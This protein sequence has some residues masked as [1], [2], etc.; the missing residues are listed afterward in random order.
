MELK[1]LHHINNKKCSSIFEKSVNIYYIYFTSSY[2]YESY[3]D[4]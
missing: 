3:S 4:S 2:T 1:Y